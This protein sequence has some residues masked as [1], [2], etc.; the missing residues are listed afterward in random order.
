MKIYITINPK[1][2]LQSIPVLQV[3]L[4]HV[5]AYGAIQG[6]V[7]GVALCVPAP[8]A[9][10]TQVVRFPYSDTVLI[11]MDL[12][13][14]ELAMVAPEEISRCLHSIEPFSCPQSAG[15]AAEFLTKGLFKLAFFQE[16]NPKDHRQA[17]LHALINLLALTH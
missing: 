15:E 14:P 5:Q 12:K 10:P 2:C 9:P 4:D 6:N 8:A 1:D 3:F 16:E 17:T 11:P 7:P 13:M